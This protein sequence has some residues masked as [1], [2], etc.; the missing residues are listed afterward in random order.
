MVSRPCFGGG[1]LHDTGK[2]SRVGRLFAKKIGEVAVDLR[3][4]FKNFVD[5]FERVR[6]DLRFGF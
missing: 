4:T 1:A 5:H 6:G 2:L 3:E